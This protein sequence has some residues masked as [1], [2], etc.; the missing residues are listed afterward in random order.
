MFTSFLS[1]GATSTDVVDEATF[2][3]LEKGITLR[4]CYDDPLDAC[5]RIAY[6]NTV[7]FNNITKALA[8]DE[9]KYFQENGVEYVYE[10]T[11]EKGNKIVEI[12]KHF[13]EFIK[14]QWGNL[15]GVIKRFIAD[16]DTLPAYAWYKT[17]KKKIDAI[18]CSK[19]VELKKPLKYEYDIN[20]G[21][22][23]ES[24]VAISKIKDD[25][26][27][28]VL[29]KHNA[30]VDPKCFTEYEAAKSYVNSM[31][32]NYTT[33]MMNAVSNKSTKKEIMA[34]VYNQIMKNA[35]GEHL[36]QKESYDYEAFSKDC[37]ALFRTEIG[38]DGKKSISGDEVKAA[39]KLISDSKNAKYDAKKLYDEVSKGLAAQLKDVNNNIKAAEKD[40]KSGNNEN[41]NDAVKLMYVGQATLTSCNNVVAAIMRAHLSAIRS[42]IY[43]ARYIVESAMSGSKKD[44]K[45]DKTVGESATASFLDSL[46][47]I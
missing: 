46:E 22:K 27:K 39:R 20:K 47:L 4:E 44:E 3:E 9:L 24:I 10:S 6:E 29:V 18:D 34:I 31:K 12:F 17:N 26:I 13:A 42:N 1:M 30:N 38:G 37:I 25:A 40:A 14:T 33:N 16:L 7:N 35:A 11:G 45:E 41:A 32:S 2:K 19:S 36:T 15:M 5:M 28:N 23:L 21:D 8:M 43:Q